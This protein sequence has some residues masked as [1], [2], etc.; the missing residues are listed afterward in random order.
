MSARRDVPLA[1][2]ARGQLEQMSRELQVGTYD[3]QIEAIATPGLSLARRRELVG[4]LFGFL[5]A[6]LE[7]TLTRTGGAR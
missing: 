7:D 5:L 4:D 1:L 2:A 6:D 3:E